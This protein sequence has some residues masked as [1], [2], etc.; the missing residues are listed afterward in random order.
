[1][2]PSFDAEAP[3]LGFPP[4]L[5][6]SNDE[7]TVDDAF[8][9]VTTSRDAAIVRHDQTSRLGFHRMPCRLNPSSTGSPPLADQ[10]RRRRRPPPSSLGLPPQ[11]ISCCR[12]CPGEPGWRG[13]EDTLQDEALPRPV[14]AKSEPVHTTLPLPL[15]RSSPLP[16]HPTALPPVLAEVDRRH[17]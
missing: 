12:S 2:P 14:G 7:D 9:K 3:E 13:R 15:R 6:K 4:E 8:T 17:L 1:V 5:P 16:P 10:L 11:T